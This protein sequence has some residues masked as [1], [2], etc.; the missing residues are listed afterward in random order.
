MS[1]D[2]IKAEMERKP[3]AHLLL[4]WVLEN[5]KDAAVRDAIDTYFVAI[6]E[7]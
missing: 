3:D 6:D 2:E 4:E 7:D 1:L 5:T